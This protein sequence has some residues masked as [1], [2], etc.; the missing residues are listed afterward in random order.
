M[1][2]YI[3]SLLFAF[4]W[5]ISVNA[6][7]GFQRDNSVTVTGI[8]G[9]DDFSM[10][11][12]GG[13]DYAQ[14]SNI[15]LNFDGVQD[16][17]VF[18]RTCNKV[19]TFLHTGGTGSENYTY[20]PEYEKLFPEMTQ[21]ALLVDYNCDGL[22]DIY[23]YTFGTAKVF[24]NTGSAA[25]GHSF[26]LEK[27]YLRTQF[28]ASEVYMYFASNDVPCF[29]DVDGDSDI[30]ALSFGVGGTA[31]EYHKNLSM[32]LYG[33]CD[34]LEFITKNTC[35]GRFQESGSTNEVTLWDTLTYPCNGV[36]TDPED[37][38]GGSH[39]RHAGSTVLAID[40]N[41]NG[42]KDLILGDVAYNNLVML[43][44]S[45]TAPNTN[46]GM[47][48]QEVNYPGTSVAVDLEIFPAPFYVD[49]NNDGVRDL[50]VGANSPIGSMNHHS[51]WY[52]RNDG[53]DNNPDFTFQQTDFLQDE[54][55]ELG[56]GSLPVFFDHNG[57]G[58][59]DLIIG[60]HG[61]YNDVTGVMEGRMSYFQNVGSAT[62]PAYELITEDYLNLGASPVGSGL[63]YYPTFGDLDND[64]DE[65]MILGE[66]FGYCFVFE[67]T[68]GAGATAIFSSYDTLRN[69][70]GEP[71][72]LSTFAY[73]KLIDLD[74]DGDL[75]LTIGRRSGKIQHFENTGTPIDPSFEW[76]TDSFGNIDVSEYWNSEGQAV[77]AFFEKDGEYQLLIGSKSGYLHYYQNIEGNLEGTF[78][79]VDSTADN[80]N[81]GTWSA[82]ALAD[83]DGDNKLELVLGNQRGGVSFFESASIELI[84][85]ENIEFN[86]DVYPNPTSDLI[87]ISSNENIIEV[88]LY[89]ALGNELFRTT[90]NVNMLE[91]N[92]KAFAKGTYLVKINTSNHSAT[93]P[94][95]LQ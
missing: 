92:L 5:M 75:D 30:D 59:L 40:L 33:V 34:S 35:W 10:A 29:T 89:D 41:A 47:I 50:I 45:G 82:P 51:G 21:W 55:I 57:D 63:S 81:I 23:T 7:F 42:V 72:F 9:S 78:T 93:K 70:L 27:P 62:S 19:L 87:I 77:P 13:Y 86:F 48:S 4:T 74:R 65:D 71:I 84:S 16:L 90:G 61:I 73:P 58:L 95:I 52:Y 15:D 44:N 3:L 38:G 60:Q 85:A 79:L 68:G 6:Q 22:P 88:M 18:D 24:K 31:I 32:E 39:D 80:L 11:W 43:M 17:F 20:A 12:A 37:I 36:L 69:H 28:G 14:F 25:T 2:R 66:Y 83:L 53:A 46:S 1:M 54:M 94:I 67:N 8:G 76:K 26:E 64:G 49:V 91:V 56:S